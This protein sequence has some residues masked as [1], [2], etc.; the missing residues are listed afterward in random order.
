MTKYK[1]T[2]AVTH[3][4]LFIPGVKHLQTTLVDGELV[5]TVNAKIE[6]SLED[7]FLKV[8]IGKYTELLPLAAV[9]NIS[10]TEV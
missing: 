7:Q 3:N 2:K 10:V 1:V 4:S 8:K 6:L 9:N 5:G